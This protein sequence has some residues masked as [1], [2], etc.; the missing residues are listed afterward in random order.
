MSVASCLLTGANQ[1]LM[2][3]WFLL[4][5]KQHK[6]HFIC[7]TLLYGA[8]HNYCIFIL[9]IRDKSGCLVYVVNVG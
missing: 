6:A 7:P 2:G 1:L 9:R 3:I 8:V 4:L 5:T